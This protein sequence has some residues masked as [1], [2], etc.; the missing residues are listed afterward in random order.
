MNELSS[1]GW[2][3]SDTL[4]QQDISDFCHML[5]EIV[6]EGMKN[7]TADGRMQQVVPL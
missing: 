4:M 7:T 2:D 3:C 5:F 1:F 6:E